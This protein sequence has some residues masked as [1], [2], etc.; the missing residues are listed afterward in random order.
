MSDV[1]RGRANDPDGADAPLPPG[2][3][4]AV[5]ATGNEGGRQP[6]VAWVA[7]ALVDPVRAA[8][9]RVLYVASGERRADEIGRALRQFAPD[10]EVLVLPAWDCLP[11]D[12]ASPSPETMGRRM[13]V[14]QRLREPQVGRCI[15]VA[16]VEALLQRTPPA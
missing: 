15:I 6:P 12:R 11:F 2:R 3:V 5:P 8:S 14:L 9:S 7:Q 10:I 13:A 1:R 16:P 4:T